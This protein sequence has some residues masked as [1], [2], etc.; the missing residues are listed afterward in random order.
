MKKYIFDLVH[1]LTMNEKSYFKKFATIHSSKTSKNYIRLFDAIAQMQGFDVQFLKKKFEGEPIAKHLSSEVNYLEEQILKSLT[2][3][4]F[5]KNKR[6]QNQ[7]HIHYITI[8]IEKGFRQRAKKI[9]K[10]T[11]TAAYQKEEFTT[12]IK[13]IQLEE[14]IFFRDKIF[15]FLEKLSKLNTERQE[16][17]AKIQNINELRLLREQ[18]SKTQFIHG[19]IDD[20]SKFSNFYNSSL[21]Q[22]PDNAFSFKAKEHWYYIKSI[23]FYLLRQYKKAQ[24][25]NLMLLDIMEENNHLSNP[26][27]ILPIASNVLYSSA[28]AKDETTFWQTMPTLEV[29]KAKPNIDKI[30]FQYV[31]HSRVLELYYQKMDLKSTTN[32]LE[33]VTPFFL[34]HHDTLPFLPLNHMLLLMVRAEIITERFQKAINWLNKWLEAGP[35]E[36]ILIH[37]RCFLLITRYELGWNELLAAELETTYKLFRRQGKYDNLAKAMV[38]FF[39]S[40]LKNPKKEI[41]YLT[42][43]HHQLKTIKAVP[44]KNHA[45]EYFNYEK[46]CEQ[47]LAKRQ[48]LRDNERF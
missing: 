29:L 39:R 25:A 46:W 8:L 12:I 44:E 18:I 7:K 41:S 33:E 21:M 35:G 45:F 9:L 32:Y 14:E 13:L 27:D 3:F 22:S 16:L 17:Y 10:K 48:N 42:T 38:A 19:Y 28:L 11:K 20:V 24:Q 36:Y 30:Y 43:L 26:S 31:K 15:D 23:Q 37:A 40:Y 4:S 6:T 1:S 2:N 47:V 34:K 5:E